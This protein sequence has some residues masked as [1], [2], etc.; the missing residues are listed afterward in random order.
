M[1]PGTRLRAHGHAHPHLCYVAEGMFAEREGCGWRRV[2]CGTLRSSPAGD[3]HDIRFETATRC[4][5]ILFEGDPLAAPTPAPRERVY[6]EAT[7]LRLLAA[8]MVRSLHC[9]SQEA[10]ELGT[11]ALELLAASRPDVA[12]RT[13]PPWLTDV[14]DRLLDD[15]RQP[16]GTADLAEWTG[17][18]PVYVAR[19]FRTH[20]GMGLGEFARVARADKAR[21]MIR[22]SDTALARLAIRAGYAD[23]SHM[24]REMR[25][26]FGTTPGR[27]RKTDPA[28]V[29][30][31]SFQGA[32]RPLQG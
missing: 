14:R 25:R 4:L 10:F 27:I 9:P 20:Y 21:S 19:A 17:L 3:E 6:L 8:E 24:T 29:E 28:A 22:S 13:P 31:A 5:L 26:V 2:P 1:R 18:H 32:G 15:P 23:Q 12:S 11:L 7:H 30:V 16:P